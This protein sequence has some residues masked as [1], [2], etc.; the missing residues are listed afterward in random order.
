MKKLFV[1]GILIVSI[2]FWS[3]DESPTKLSSDDFIIK[4][5]DS[6]TAEPLPDYTLKFSYL[7]NEQE[8]SGLINEHF[9][10]YPNPITDIAD[11][12]ISLYEKSKLLIQ[13]ENIVTKHNKIVYGPFDAAAGNYQFE[14]NLNDD[15]LFNHG[16]F[17]LYSFVN[18]VKRD[19]VNMIRINQNDWQEFMFN[20]TLL[21]D[22]FS[23]DYNGIVNPGLDFGIWIGEEFYRTINNGQAVGD[24]NISEN[25]G[26]KVYNKENQIVK[27]LVIPF[28]ELKKGRIII[29]I[30][31]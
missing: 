10:L 22:I 26:I 17:R 1:F 13:A 21:I 29:E 27:E 2:I 18:D 16:F 23:S 28:D 30:N 12:Q 4:L 20:K 3:C 25:F 7:F 8:F 11:V 9:H 5:V 14:V 24:I 19:S 31:K 6:V 15:S